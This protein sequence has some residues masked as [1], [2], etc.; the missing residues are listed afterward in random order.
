M[1]LATSFLYNSINSKT[2]VDTQDPAAF[3][4]Q[5]QNPKMGA[6]KALKWVLE[7]PEIA[8]LSSETGHPPW[9][10]TPNFKFPDLGVMAGGEEKILVKIQANWKIYFQSAAAGFSHAVA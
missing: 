1:S 3:T 9:N 7:W 10:H 4:L 6:P 5:F 2:A 8:P